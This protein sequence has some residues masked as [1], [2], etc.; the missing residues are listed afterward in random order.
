MPFKIDQSAVTPLYD[1]SVVGTAID[2]GTELVRMWPL[3]TAQEMENDAR[4]AE[5]L[6]VRFS[7]MMAQTLLK[8]PDEIDTSVAEA[9]YEGMDVIP[10]CEQDVI[11]ALMDANHAYDVMS[12]YSETNDADLFF[13]AATT[14][15]IHLDPVI[16]R[17]IRGILRSVAKTIRNTS[18]IPVDNEV[19][20][21]IGL[22]LPATRNRNTLTSRYLGSLTVSDALMNLMCYGFD[23]P[24]ERA[25]RV[26]PV[27]LYANELR[28]Q[29]AVPH[30]SLNALDLRHLIELRDSAFRD[31]E[32][33]VSVRRNAFNARTFTAS[34]RFLAMLSG[35]EWALHAKYLRW[36]PKQAEKEANEE[37]ERRNKQ[38]L[39]DKF[40]HVKDDPD[41]PEV[42]L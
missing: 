40:K 18:G 14:L 29:F 39:A 10:G 5:D 38:A 13:E 26:L 16:E 17:D 33:A 12:G 7:R 21:S 34:V 30:T 36:D 41:K 1:S 24:Q 31:D 11:R 35:Q 20:A 22:C 3:Q 32:H 15:G 27:L 8:L 37:D 4:Y 19:A 6:Q 28:E 9:V 2:F 42:D 23:D 25:M